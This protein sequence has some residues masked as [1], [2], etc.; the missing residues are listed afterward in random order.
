MTDMLYVVDLRSKFDNFKFDLDKLSVIEAVLELQRLK[1]LLL[2][3]SKK[4]DNSDIQ[5]K[6]LSRLPTS[7]YWH[8]VKVYAI[9]AEKD[10]QS[11][12]TTLLSF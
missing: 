7:D 10:L 11:T 8:Q 6:L 5:Y 4:I 2:T 1:T 12:I 3:T 9:T